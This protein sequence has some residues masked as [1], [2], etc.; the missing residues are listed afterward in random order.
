MG[1]S[2]VTHI[3]DQLVVR[4]VKNMMKGHCKFHHAKAENIL[5]FGPNGIELHFTDYGNIIQITGEN[6]DSIGIDNDPASNASGK[7]SVQEILS[8]G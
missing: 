7:S 5:C 1:I 6:L 4:R 8:I 2:L 3:P